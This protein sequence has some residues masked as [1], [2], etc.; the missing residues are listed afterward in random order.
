MVNCQRAPNPSEI[1][2]TCTRGPK[3]PKQTCTNSRPEA[4]VCKLRTGTNLH[5]FAPPR[6]RLPSGGPTRVQIRVGL[7]P[8]EIVFG[9]NDTQWFNVEFILDFVAQNGLFGIPF[10]YPIIPLKKCLVDVSDILYFFLLGGGEGGSEAPERGWEGSVFD[11][12]SPEGGSPRREEGGGGGG[13]RGAGRVSAGNFGGLIFFFFGAE[14]PPEKVHVGH[15]FEFFP[16]KWGT[17]T[18]LQG[19]PKL[20]ILSGA[21]KVFMLK[22]LVWF[23]CPHQF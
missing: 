4:L 15:L 17:S 21:Q 22:K 3:R 23:Y 6:G 12:K 16:R 20:S 9:I 18:F 13:G 2:P 10:V 1:A 14:I 7:E 11:W 5:K 8:A 19:G